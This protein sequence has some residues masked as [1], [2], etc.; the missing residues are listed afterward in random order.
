MKVLTGLDR[1]LADGLSLPGKGRYGLL[2]NHATVS[3]DLTPAV[4]ALVAAGSGKLDRIFAPQHGFA[5]EKQDNMVESGHGSHSAT[6][7][8]IVS[9]YGAVREPTDEMLANLDA[10]LIDVPDV[11]TRVYTFLITAWYLVVAAARNNVPVWILDRPNPIGGMLTDGPVLE[12]G[13]RSFVGQIPV[14]LQHGLTTAEYLRFGLAATEHDVSLE[15][16]PTLGWTREMM[17]DETGLPWVFPSPNLPTLDTALVYPGG[18]ALEGT[19]LSE[20]RGTTRPF[21]LFGAPWLN[22]NAVARTARGPGLD[23]CTLRNVAFEPTFHKF[24]K[25]T[26]R[27]FQ[28]HVTDR[29]RFRPVLAFATLFSAIRRCHADDFGWRESRYE[30]ESERPAIDLIFGAPRIRAAID[31]G[32]GAEELAELWRGDIDRFRAA[33]EEHLLYR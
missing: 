4:E 14:P 33:R 9:L 12:A 26:V 13:Q 28:I 7:V 22:P 32:A 30:Y 23:G 5:G 17:F 19:N 16:I 31:A 25:E 2:C 24:V 15:V 11:G 29:R 3:S 6:G 27:G 1:I 10:I 20:G 21:E 18:V 8:P